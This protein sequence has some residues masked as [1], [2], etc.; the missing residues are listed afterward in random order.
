VLK[1]KPPVMPGVF[2]CGFARVVESTAQNICA[3]TK[4]AR[5]MERIVTEI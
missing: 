2:R 5:D 1:E 3:G 4:N